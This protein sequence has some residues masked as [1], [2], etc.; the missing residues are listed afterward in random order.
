MHAWVDGWKQWKKLLAP[1]HR[2]C[3]CY[4]YM[5]HRLEEKRQTTT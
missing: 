5:L 3:L 2:R 1:L 4:S